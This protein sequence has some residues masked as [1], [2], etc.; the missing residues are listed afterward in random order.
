VFGMALALTLI[1]LA[2]AWRM[3]ALARD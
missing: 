1:W 3:P 2:V